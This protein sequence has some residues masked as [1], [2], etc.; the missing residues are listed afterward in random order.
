MRAHAAFDPIWR[1][2]FKRKKRMGRKEA[3]AWLA[4]KLHIHRD[5]C[6]IGLFNESQCLEVLEA[7]R[8]LTG[9]S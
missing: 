4:G 5:L 8:R 2:G 7:V 9:N 1:G 3:Y 6:H